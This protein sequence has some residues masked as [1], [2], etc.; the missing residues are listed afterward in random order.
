MAQKLKDEK[1]RIDIELDHMISGSPVTGNIIINVWKGVDSTLTEMVEKYYATFSVDKGQIGFRADSSKGT[2][3]I[4]MLPENL[5]DKLF[6]TL[7]TIYNTIN[8]Q[9]NHYIWNHPVTEK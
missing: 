7:R 4:P 1:I 8:G 6:D 9:N 3:G 5:D 2:L